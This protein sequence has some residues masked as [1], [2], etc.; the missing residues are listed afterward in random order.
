[1]KKTGRKF[2]LDA[3]VLIAAHRSYYAFELC[4]GFWS[5]VQEGFHAGRIFS[6][7]RVRAE[8]AGGGDKLARWIVDELP[9]DFFLDDANGEVM[10]A[11]A[12]MMTWVAGR[13]FLPAAKAKFASDTDGWLVAAA[14]KSGLCVVTHETLQ[15]G[16]K[17]RVKIPNVCEEF[18]VSYCDT[19]EMLRELE[20]SYR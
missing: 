19:F 16:V 12:P 17:A 11:F 3:N 14:K 9:A 10:A 20:C 7:Q 5:S 13:D 8:L 1:M 6:T 15:L 18:G 4:P 2:L